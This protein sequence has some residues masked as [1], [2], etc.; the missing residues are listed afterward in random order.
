MNYSVSTIS[1]LLHAEV[2]GN[3]SSDAVIKDLLIDSRKLGN[4]VTCLF[5]AIKGERHD[6][7]TYINDLYQKG[8][9]NFVVSQLPLNH[10][11]A[12]RCLFYFGA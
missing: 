1:S 9:R 12:Y 7:H 2:N 5:F 6:G 3:V 11:S 4:P 8:V 10:I